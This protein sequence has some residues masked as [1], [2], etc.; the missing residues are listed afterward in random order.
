MSTKWVSVLCLHDES[1]DQRNINMSVSTWQQPFHHV[2]FRAAYIPVTTSSRACIFRLGT[3][4]S[5]ITVPHL[6]CIWDHKRF[7]ASS[8]CSDNWSSAT[9]STHLFLSMLIAT[10][11]ASC[12]WLHEMLNSA[13][14]R[15]C[16]SFHFKQFFP[17]H[18]KQGSL[19]K[20]LLRG[21]HARDMELAYKNQKY[22]W[23]NDIRSR[24]LS[25]AA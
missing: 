10:A 9:L 14:V 8:S 12:I 3:L 22:P 16:G 2:I 23:K 15:Q 25:Q 5:Q 17:P 24:G 11:A 1:P 19:S 20:W 6:Y 21:S 7:S 4:Q 13:W 18:L